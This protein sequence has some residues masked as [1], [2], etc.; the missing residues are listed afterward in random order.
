MAIG[1][2]GGKDATR[3]TKSFGFISTSYLFLCEI[4]GLFAR[5]VPSA[6]TPAR[7]GPTDPAPAVGVSVGLSAP[8]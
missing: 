2:R 1:D 5:R 4:Y 7:L 6:R 3:N 8:G